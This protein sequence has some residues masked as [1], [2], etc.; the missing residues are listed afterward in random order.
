MHQ[1]LASG[2]LS[3]A[4]LLISTYSYSGATMEP[5][6][7]NMDEV[8]VVGIQVVG[9]PQTGEFGGAWPQLFQRS[10]EIKH[11]PVAAP[12]DRISFGVQSYDKELMKKGVWKYTAAV[13]V[14]EGASTPEG[15]AQVTL[16]AHQ[17]AVFEYRGTVGSMLDELFGY[18]Y[19]EWLP[20]SGYVVAAP[21]DF[22]L[23]D[24]RFKGP[25]DENSI[26]EIYVPVKAR[27]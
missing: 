10:N 21:F 2:F 26:L 14:A 15:M 3:I 9:S 20:K 16:P 6:I 18:I 23:Y 1:S 12:E 5:K 17:Y 4:L 25:A 19:R 7:V 11:K 24:Q 13:E 22:E 8:K 27:Q